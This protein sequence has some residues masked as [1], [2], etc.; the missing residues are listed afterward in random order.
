MRPQQRPRIRRRWF[1]VGAIVLIGFISISSIVRFYTDLLWFHELHFAAVFWKIVWTR[2]GIGVA[3]GVLAGIVLFANL[4]VAR[5]TAPRHRFVT[6]GSDLTEQ[7]R[8]AF[9]PYARLAN[10]VVAAVVAFFTGLSTSATWQRY[11]LWKNAVPFGRQAPKPFGRDIAFYVFSIPFQ[12]AILS[13]L[14]GILVVSVLLSGVAHLFNGSIQPETNRVRVATVVKAHLSVLFGLIALVKAWAYRLDV[15]DLV[16]SPRGVVT[17]ASYTD[18]HVQRK[19]LQLLIVIAV[20]AAIIFFVNVFRF[21]GWI[22][23]GAAIGLWLFVSVLLGGIVP[24]AVQ[25]F[26]VKPNES[27]KER[28]Y[29]ARN[30]T[31]T[32]DAFDL[33]KI[34]AQTFNPQNTLSASIVAQNEA[35]IRNV[36]VW[37]P[38]V[39]LPTYQRLQAIRSYYT[40]NDVDVD[41]YEI[42]GRQTQVML[43]GRELDASK[44]SPGSRNWV[45]TRL[46][47]T[48]GYGFVANPANAQTAE[49]L[50]DFD[51]Q[52]L[53]PSAPPALSVKQPGLYYGEELAPGSYSVVK[54]K[55]PEIDYPKGEQQVIT[56]NYN[57]DGGIALSNELRR[58]AFAFRFGDTDLLVS[59]FITPRSRLIMRRNIVE[60]VQAAAP[61]LQYDSDP[62]LVAAQGKLYWIIDGYTDTD[63]YPYSQRIDLGAQGIGHLSGVA[64]YMRNSVKVVID[65][66]N[67]TTRFYVIDPSDPLIETYQKTFP[68][69]FTPMSKM[70][71]DLVAHLRYPEDL[72]TVQAL[73][74]RAYHILD[75]QRLYSREDIWDIANDPVKST[76]STN[77]RM[78]AYYVIMKLPGESHE[79]FVLML[80][81]TPT[82]KPNL[83]GWLAARMDPG[84]YGQMVAFSFPRGAQIEGPEN[85]FARINQNDKISAQFTLWNQAGSTVEKGNIYVLPIGQTLLYVEPI[86]LAAE[87]ESQTLPELR[88]VITVVGN[89]SIGF[90]PTFNASLADVVNGQL[91][92]TTAPPAAPSQPATTTPSNVATL[93]TQAEQHFNNA[94]AALRNGD[95]ATYQKEEQAGRADVQ[96]AAQATSK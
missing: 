80:P 71:K 8:S 53:P 57:G 85:I 48:H 78:A 12:R 55:Q 31:A 96:Q 37:D 40:F 69:L 3:G 9:R 77:V 32:R 87:Q 18:V 13:W 83:N 17:G 89:G 62:Y 65:A 94:D 52:D 39:L 5:R 7:Y 95:L 23:P 72:F 61:F 60:R 66:Y 19:A 29:I 22:L 70:P 38:A 15:Y 93:L 90:E 44:L 34:N 84:H 59:N 75:P 35:T 91:P 86:Y 92:Q 51:V 25:R 27:Q 20:V 82:G 58:L 42:D 74:Y 88:R 54:T 76:N 64:N 11:L 68:Q 6:A 1:I 45:N 36:R 24:A 63:R 41:R 14:F 43:S 21:Q 33:N 10:L 67:G 28:P 46:T 4:E 81:F 49:G 73:Q 2:V 16:F 30:I 47:Y 79:E 26:E 56:T 50:P